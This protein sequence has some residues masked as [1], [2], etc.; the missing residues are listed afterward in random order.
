MMFVCIK[1][2]H[3]GS[4]ARHGRPHKLNTTPGRFLCALKHVVR[5]ELPE[6]S[7][8]S[9]SHF[10]RIHTVVQSCIVRSGL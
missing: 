4:P 10:V 7:L 6:P 9:L 2:K 5:G 1:F 8:S 3:P